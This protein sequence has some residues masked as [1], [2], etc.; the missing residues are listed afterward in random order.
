MMADKCPKCNSALK[1]VVIKEKGLALACSN[2][3]CELWR[4]VYNES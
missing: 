2:I 3:K 1:M 4:D